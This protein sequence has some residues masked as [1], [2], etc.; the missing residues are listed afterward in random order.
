MGNGHIQ[1]GMGTQP[2]GKPMRQG[3]NKKTRTL[4]RLLV[5]N[6]FYS[7]LVVGYLLLISAATVLGQDEALFKSTPLNGEFDFSHMMVDGI[8]EYLDEQTKKSIPDRSSFWN[9]DFSNKQAYETSVSPNR[10]RLLEILGAVDPILPNIEMEKLSTTETSFLLGENKYFE[11]FSVRWQVLEGVY[12]EG[13]LLQPKGKIRSRVVALPDADQTPEELVGMKVG[14]QENKQY[15]RILAENGC[16]VIIPTIIDRSSHGSG[17]ERMERFTNQP[18][19]EWIYRQAYTFGR[20]IIGYEVQKIRVALGWF[21]HLNK[22]EPLK[23]GVVGWGEGA[24]LAF[25]TAAIDTRINLAYISGYFSKREN[26][27]QEPIYRN[28][29]GYLKEF[30]DAEVASLIVPRTLMIEYSK[31]PE[32]NGPPPALDGPSRVGASAAPGKI[33]TPEFYRVEEE[34]VRA[35]H[36]AGKFHP[37]IHFIHEGGKTVESLNRTSIALFLEHLNSD[38]K[39]RSVFGKQI[40]D[41]RTGFDPAERQLRQV[42]ELEEYTQDLISSSRHRRDAFFWD[43]MEPVEL[44]SWMDQKKYFQDYLW[45]E[46]IGRIPQETSLTIP[47]SRQ[48]YDEETWT[49]HEIILDVIPEIF[50]WGY[51]LVPKGLEKGE[52]RP[53]MVVMHGGSGLP[54]V[55][56]DQQNKTYKGLAVQLVEQGYVVFAPHFPWRAGDDYRNLQRKANPLGL[57][58]FSVIL[59]QHEKLLDW[60]TEQSFVDPEKIGF[61]GLSWGGKVAVRVPALLER[62]SLSIC[63]GDFNEWIWKNATTDWPNS[64][65]FVPEYEMFDFNLGLTFNYGEMAALMAPR[66]FMVERGHDDGVGIDEWV[67]FEYA[68]VNRLYDQLGISEKTAIEYFN[69][70]HEINAKGTFQFIKQHFGW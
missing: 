30:G 19:R 49:G 10:Q 59:H 26:L 3:P 14:L 22:T 45:D 24:L 25:Y 37:S 27:W 12:G 64:Y 39:L 16:Q 42:K 54:E 5:W 62:Y 58:V 1:L 29:W 60:L 36:L 31:V 9:P 2:T 34:V 11:V 40:L 32:I 52:K 46:I 28:L 4:N 6:G 53:V 63:S 38:Q 23:I 68:K 15:A 47:K 41:G 35:R 8:G 18:H 65:M 70:G 51:F 33:D 61:Y 21:E 17:S 55:V 50:L 43:K 13:L 67:A 69:G 56:M 20:H 57:S 48:I 7:L 44:N 66:A